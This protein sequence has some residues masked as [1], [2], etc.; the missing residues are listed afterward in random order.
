[1]RRGNDDEAVYALLAE[2]RAIDLWNEAGDEAVSSNPVVRAVIDQGLGHIC[3]GK[4]QPDD[5]LEERVI[6][7]ETED[8]SHA[9]AVLAKLPGVHRVGTSFT[10]AAYG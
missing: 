7:L 6:R 3:I 10:E 9:S 2:H 1:M 5:H 4:L 8:V